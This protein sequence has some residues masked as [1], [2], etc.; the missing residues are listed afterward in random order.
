[1]R[2]SGKRWWHFLHSSKLGFQG[3]LS[4]SGVIQ[5]T[6]DRLAHDLG[7]SILIEDVQQY[8][9]WWCTVGPVDDVR[10]RTILHRSVERAAAD[11]VRKFKLRQ[12]TEPVRTPMLKD[13]GMWPRWAIPVRHGDR[14][15]GLLWVLDPDGIVTDSDLAQLVELADLAAAELVKAGLSSEDEQAQRD[16]LIAELLRGP[17]TGA[18]EDLAARA[19]LPTDPMVQVECPAQTDGWPLPGDMSA[20]VFRGRER[21]ATSGG[22]LPL[23]NLAEAVRRASVT[24]RAVAA[25]A[26]LE[27]PTYD[28]LGAWLLV[29]EAPPDLEPRSVHPAVEILAAQPRGDLLGTVRTVL[30]LGNDV[31]AA[32]EVLHLHR[33]TLYYRIDRLTELTGVDL[34]DGRARTDLQFALWLHAYRAAQD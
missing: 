19:H 23:A 32:A 7:L 2:E 8:P 5:K 28:A 18:A 6:V 22:P 25:G 3:G 30:D 12:A 16:S 27:R 20:H 21:Q 14:P 13:S 31:S 10:S 9:V 15:L 17:N 24:R 34:R 29:V 4:L 26:R 11:V 1:M 33:T